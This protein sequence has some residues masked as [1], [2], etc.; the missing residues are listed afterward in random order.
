MWNPVTHTLGH[1][2]R[3]NKW[4][5]QAKGMT[6]ENNFKKPQFKKKDPS[7]HIYKAK[8]IDAKWPPGPALGG[9][10]SPNQL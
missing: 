7:T 9:N 2:L 10:A 6:C 1:F 3:I 4:E 8:S 5:N